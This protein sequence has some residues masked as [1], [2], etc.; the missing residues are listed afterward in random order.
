[1]KYK[2]GQEATS[3]E[4]RSSFILQLLAYRR[5]QG[6]SSAMVLVYLLIKCLIQSFGGICTHVDKQ[7]ERSL[8]NG[9]GKV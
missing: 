3:E 2:F 1:M 4:C 9:E 7:L 6:S 5:L 8:S